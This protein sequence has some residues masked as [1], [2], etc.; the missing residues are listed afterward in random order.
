MAAE[1]S[2]TPEQKY[3]RAHW[4]IIKRRDFLAAER[5]LTEFISA[6]RSHQLAPNAYYWLGRTYF[7]RSNFEQAAITFA[8][9]FQRFPKSKK[10]PVTLLNLGNSL[11]RLGKNR[12]ACMTYRKLQKNFRQIE[13]A[14]KRRLDREQKRSKCLR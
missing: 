12:E 5:V 2:E 7:V 10:A 3:D 6:N 4:L 8:E 14:V 13:E 1:T 9:G 11:S